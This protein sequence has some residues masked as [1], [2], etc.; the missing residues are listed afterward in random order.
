MTEAPFDDLSLM[1]YA[2]GE[3]DP[4][5]AAAVERAMAEDKRV[6][7]RVAA[8]AETRKAAKSAYSAE[9]REPL[10]AALVERV[11]AAIR[12]ASPETTAPGNVASLPLRR[13]GRA[14]SQ[15]RWSL[16]LAAC[17]AA[18]AGLFLGYLM[19]DW[20]RPDSGPGLGIEGISRAALT[21]MLNSVPSGQVAR[22]PAGNGN[23]QLIA[24]FRDGGGA[25]CREFSLAAESA[26]PVVAVA[27]RQAQEWHLTFAAA[28]P[29]EDG[30]YS[31]ASSVHV[32]DAYLE[33]I[34]AGQPLTEA[35]EKAALASAD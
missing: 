3:L 16:P 23:V 5:T 2:D 31:T 27:C 20:D 19:A 1:A 18:L 14:G 22:L 26:A 28:A 32:A 25:L 6:A 12:K 8:F 9:L 10:P 11:T 4:A 34:H 13:A 30:S 7:A 35:E 29:R 17:V 21:G 33:A 15:P 24:S